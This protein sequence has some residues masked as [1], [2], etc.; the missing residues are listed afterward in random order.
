MIKYVFYS[1]SLSLFCISEIKAI[2][3]LRNSEADFEDFLNNLYNHSKSGNANTSGDQNSFR[4]DCR[5]RKT[6]RKK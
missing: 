4:G 1:M 5:R 3:V 2:F 6:K